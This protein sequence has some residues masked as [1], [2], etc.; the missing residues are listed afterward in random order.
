LSGF[1]G[2]FH[3][4]FYGLP[5]RQSV[6]MVVTIHDLTFEDHPRW[7]RMSQRAAF[8]AQARHA[9]RSARRILTVSEHARHRIIDR[10]QVGEERV[11][12]TPPG[13]D[14]RFRPDPDRGALHRLLE[15]LRVK[16]PYLVALGGARRRALW[17]A[18]EAWRHL[19]AQGAK[20][21][22]VVVGPE[23]PPGE[24]GLV[25][26]GTLDD[27]A[28]ALLLAGAEAFCYPTGY[29]GFGMPALEA[30]A[31]GTPVVCAPVGALPE[32]MGS[33]AAWCEPR[34]PEAIASRLRRLLQDS[35]DAKELQD[36]GLKVAAARGGWAK[37]ADV[38]LKA[39][40]ESFEG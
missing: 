31:S 24:P 6:P 4:P 8:R 9:A 37:M 35:E 39:Y 18:V 22:L 2:L 17:M 33:A 30:A 16:T 23:R 13:V 19:G 40:R 28:W 38:T 15:S 25:H 12:V 5:Y 14:Q 1:T 29:E 36:K 20:V 21:A 7:F 27:A 32:V 34:T 11:L 26:A 10:Y 3:C